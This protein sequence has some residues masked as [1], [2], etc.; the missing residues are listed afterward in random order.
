VVKSCQRRCSEKEK[1]FAWSQHPAAFPRVSRLRKGGLD[2]ANGRRI[3]EEEGAICRNEL[4]APHDRVACA[5]AG[6]RADARCLEQSFSVLGDTS[7]AHT[8]V[9]A[10]RT[11]HGINDSDK[12]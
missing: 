11:D 9:Y 3:D 2:F 6:R 8:K 7:R 10:T 5:R 12:A 1:W 4:A